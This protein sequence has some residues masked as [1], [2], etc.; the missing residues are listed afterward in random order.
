M[1]APEVPW[2]QHMWTRTAFPEV[3]VFAQAYAASTICITLLT[4]DQF[5]PLGT[6]L[7]SKDRL[8]IAETGS[9]NFWLQHRVILGC[10]M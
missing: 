9:L 6:T 3:F 2:L 1:A 7:F 8:C 10:W 5:M 4:C